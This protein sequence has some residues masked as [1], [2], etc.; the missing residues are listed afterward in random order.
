MQRVLETDGGDVRATTRM[1]LMALNRAFKM[2]KM[3]NL[4]F[5]HNLLKKRGGGGDYPMLKRKTLGR[6]I[7]HHN[8]HQRTIRLGCTP[9]YKA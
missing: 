9:F 4:L 5:S 7:S 1:Y 3:V 8:K 2:V 6:S